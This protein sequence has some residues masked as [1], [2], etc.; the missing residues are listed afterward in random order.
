MKVSRLLLDAL[1]TFPNFVIIDKNANVV[2]LNESYAVLLGIQR[3]AAIGKPVQ[4]V[5]PGTRLHL[6]LK[7]QKKEVGELMTLFDHTVNDYITVVCNRMPIFRD[8]QLV[9]AAAVTTMQNIT[10]TISR[11]HSEIQDIKKENAQ[12]KKELG[13]FNEKKHSIHWTVLSVLPIR[14]LKSKVQLKILHFLIFLF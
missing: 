9:G 2:Y 1:E 13:H 14:L 10:E 7:S 5:I 12:Y 6:V 4:S 3:D 8:G 11:L